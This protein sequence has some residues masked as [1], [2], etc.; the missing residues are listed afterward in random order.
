[1]VDV[2][3]AI[4]EI[5]IQGITTRLTLTVLGIKIEVNFNITAAT[6]VALQPVY[7]LGYF[8]CTSCNACLDAKCNRFHVAKW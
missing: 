5:L 7:P 1:M 6:T 2:Y 3:T 4:T 8:H